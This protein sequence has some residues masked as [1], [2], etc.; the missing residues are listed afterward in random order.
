MYWLLYPNMISTLMCACVYTHVLTHSCPILCHPIDCSP[1]VPLS[2]EFSRQEYWNRLPFPTLQGTFLTQGLNPYLLHPLHWQADSLPLCH[3]GRPSYPNRYYQIVTNKCKV[4]ILT[5]D[6][7]EALWQRPELN[8]QKCGTEGMERDGT[9][10]W[11]KLLLRKRC[12]S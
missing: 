5:S 4:K 3:L 6:G 10:I 9:I 2:M 11:R 1:Q 7:N 8:S 12:L